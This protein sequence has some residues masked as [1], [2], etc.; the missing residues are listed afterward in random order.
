MKIDFKLNGRPVHLD[1][2]GERRLLWVLRND[3]GLT[4]AKYGCGSAHCGA[5]TVLLNGKAVRT[6]TLPVRAVAGRSVT[7]IEGLASDGVLSPIQQAFVDHDALQCGFC[8][9]GMILTAH[10]LLSANPQPTREQIVAGMDRN[11]CRC[12]AYRRIRLAIES[13]AARTAGRV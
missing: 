9:P 4:G 6:C 1:T 13:A 2:D 11:L 5:C 7:T 12:S 10:A 8:T 3:L